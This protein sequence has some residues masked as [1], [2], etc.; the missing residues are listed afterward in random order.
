MSYGIHT[1]FEKTLNRQTTRK[2]KR[3]GE[4]EREKRNLGLISK[5]PMSELAKSSL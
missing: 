1:E 5:F 2:R 3:E 4:R